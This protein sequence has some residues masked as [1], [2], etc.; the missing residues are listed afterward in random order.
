[1]V[2]QNLIKELDALSSNKERKEY[3]NA[4]LRNPNI[5]RDSLK[6][7]ACIA[8]IEDNFIDKYYKYDFIDFIKKRVSKT[9]NFFMRFLK[10]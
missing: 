7:I 1:M 5:S 3:I 6:R 8:L 4:I 9:L 10:K 2:F